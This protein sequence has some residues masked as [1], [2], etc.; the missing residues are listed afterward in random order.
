MCSSASTQKFAYLRHGSFVIFDDW[1]M[2]MVMV[3]NRFL[4]IPKSVIIDILEIRCVSFLFL[5]ENSCV[6]SGQ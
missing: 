2:M 1:T 5:Q 4:L 3:L 6:A